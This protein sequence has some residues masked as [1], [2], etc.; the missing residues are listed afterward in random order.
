MELP[1]RAANNETFVRHRSN[2]E[3]GGENRR[4]G[5]VCAIIALLLPPQFFF[6]GKPSLWLGCTNVVGAVS[7]L[8]LDLMEV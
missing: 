4:L 3:K 6:V 7:S 2:E 5:Y 8:S 1:T